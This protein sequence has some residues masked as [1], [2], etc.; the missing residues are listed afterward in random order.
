M[1]ETRNERAL[2]G[3]AFNGP[4]HTPRTTLSAGL[5]SLAVAVAFLSLVGTASAA[6]HNGTINGDEAQATTCAVGSTS[7]IV[8]TVTFDD[9]TNLFS[10]SYTYGDNAPAYDDGDVFNSGTVSTAH[11]HGPA[12]I[13]VPASVTVAT[14]PGTPNSG[15]ATITPT[16]GADLLGELWYLNV[17]TSS[18]GGGELRGQVLFPPAPSV[19]MTSMP[20]V[21]TLLASLLATALYLSRRTSQSSV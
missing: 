11:F 1:S 6:V 17:H 2:L 12:A 16:Q 15:S 4:Q 7:Q 5:I 18:C 10:W 20:V 21:V 13:G 3:A 19:P 8:G 14:G 9:V